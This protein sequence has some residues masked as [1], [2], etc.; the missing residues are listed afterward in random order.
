MLA[1]GNSRRC[2]FFQVNIIARAV[3]TPLICGNTVILRPSEYSPKS[4][5]LVVRTPKEAGLPPGCLNFLPTNAAKVPSVTEFAV[6]HRLVRK[7]NL[8]GSSRVG[9]VTAGWAASCL[10]SC[11]LECGDKAPVVVL[12]DADLEDAVQAILFGTLSNSGQICM[13]EFPCCRT[14]P[15]VLFG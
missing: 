12:D 15:M 6:K 13:Y 2:D 8:A 1:S 11:L 14:L 10:K 9:K 7:I 4:Q 5:H 3:S